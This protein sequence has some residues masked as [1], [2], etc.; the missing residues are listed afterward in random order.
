[1]KSLKYISLALTMLCCF[2]SF[3]QE[4]IF[5]FGL[6]L[7]NSKLVVNKSNDAILELANQGV[8][9]DTEGYRS[10]FIRLIESSTNL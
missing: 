6:K 1:M 3:S 9:N 2:L 5:W 8:T 7:R 4:K 10:E